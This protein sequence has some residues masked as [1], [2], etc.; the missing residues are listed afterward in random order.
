MLSCNL[1]YGYVS[2][3]LIVKQ[4]KFAEEKIMK[5]TLQIL[6]AYQITYYI[7]T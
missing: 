3:I 7:G 6:G 1:V 5:S 2:K 4:N